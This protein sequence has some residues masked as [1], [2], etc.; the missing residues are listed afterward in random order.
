MLATALRRN[1]RDSALDDLQQRLLNTLARHIAG[2]RGVLALAGDL[3]DLVDINNALLGFLDIVV[4]RLDQL[5]EDILNIL[6]DIP[7]LGQRGR[8]SDR[9]GNI[10]SARQSLRQQGLTYAGRPE[11]EDVGLGEIDILV[12]IEHALVVVIDRYGKRLFRG[13]LTDDI[14]I[15]DLLDLHRL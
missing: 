1:I 7:R 4:S 9:K 14:L 15:K 11:H 6:A 8:V 3:V 13:V 12:V 2:D 5:Q 10:Q